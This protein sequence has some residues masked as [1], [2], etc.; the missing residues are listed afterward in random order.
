MKQKRVLLIIMSVLLVSALFVLIVTACKGQQGKTGAQGPQGETGETGPKGDSGESAYDVWLANGH[1]GSEEDFLDWLKG[2]KGDQGPQGEKGDQGTIGPQ[3]EKGDTGDTGAQGPQGEKGETGAQGATG[4]KGDSGESAYDV[5]L[6]NGHSGSEEDFLN[7]LK[8]EKGDTGVAG[9]K[10]DKGE[11]G[12][13]GPQGEKGDTGDTGAQGEK[14]EKGI[15]PHIGENGHWWIGEVDTGVSA[16]AVGIE[17]IVIDYNGHVTITLSDGTTYEID[18]KNPACEHVFSTEQ[19][20]PT[21]EKRGYT[22]YTCNTCGY[23]YINDYVPETGHHYYNGACV[24]CKTPEKYDGPAYS[25]EW[26]ASSSSSFEIKTPQ[27]LAGLAYLVNSGTNFSGKTVYLANNINLDNVEWIPIGSG[28]STPFAGTFNGRNF[29]VSN[30]KISTQTQYVGLFGY[31][32]GAISNIV[33]T[34]TNITVTTYEKTDYVGI[35]CGYTTS[36]VSGVDTAGFVTA[37]N[38]NNV[39]GVVGYTTGTVNDCSSSATVVG[40]ENV[41]GIVGQ[42]LNS[43]LKDCESSST[44]SGTTRVGGVAGHIEYNGTATYSSLSNTGN[45]TATG[46][47]VGG[48]IGYLYN[49]K[50]TSSDFTLRF[51]Y[52]R[53]SGIISGTNYIGGIIGYYYAYN[54][55]TGSNRTIQLI[56]LDLTN[57]GNVTASGD[58]VGGLAGYAYGGANSYIEKSSSNATV[59]GRAYVGGLAGYLGNITIKN[60]SNEG[61]SVTSNGYIYTDTTPSVYLGGYVGYGY[62]VTGCTNAVQIT[63]T[64]EGQCVG[65]IAGCSAGVFTDCTNNADISGKNHVGGIAGSIVYGGSATYSNLE[66]TGEVTATGDYVGGLVGYL[67][68]IK[69]T[70]TN[71]TLRFEYIRNSATVNGANYV[72]GLIGYVYAENKYSGSNRTIKLISLELTNTGNISATSDYVGG[73]FGYAYSDDTSST[74]QTYSSTGTVQGNGSHVDNLIGSKTNINY[75]A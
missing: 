41:G 69:D 31:V 60:S 10:G 20:D 38:C 72:G 39:G 70:S 26:Y 67:Y 43:S 1:S 24:W 61:S 23:S 14:G 40:S 15:S 47:Y 56:S 28:S 71:F 13:Q 63:Y 8:G 75:V 36:S 54:K 9:P 58:Y 27:D 2:E 57:T 6:A 55:Y 21:C 49:I 65:G 16:K 48:L 51:E 4:P 73:L 50:D 7:W 12:A 30:L 25:T 53:N 35:L 37:D 17:N 33:L 44:V 11:T 45:V 64:S 3:G 74:I 66:N 5:W 18:V 29:V 52:N 42:Y 22:K 34:G 46:D 32:T 68:N 59:S 19:V 62:S